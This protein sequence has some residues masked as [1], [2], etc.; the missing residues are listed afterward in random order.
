VQCS[1]DS[2]YALL[3]DPVRFAPLLPDYESMELHDPTHFTLRTVIA[4]GKMDG[5]ANLQMEVSECNP[6]SSVRY[7]GEGVVAGSK[8][9]FG[10]GFRL[11]AAGDMTKVLWEGEVS[12]GGMLAFLAGDLIE[13]KGR[14]DFE[15]MAGRVRERLSGNM[16]PDPYSENPPAAPSETSGDGA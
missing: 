4:V 5:H 2:V 11:S 9:V 10:I 15:R 13:T 7:R 3:A 6:L 12:V 16:A 1:T 8:I 14:A